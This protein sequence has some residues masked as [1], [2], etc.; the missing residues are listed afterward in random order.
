MRL[1]VKNIL[2]KQPKSKKT[3][4]Y[5][6]GDSWVLGFGPE[7]EVL[8]FSSPSVIVI[9]RLLVATITRIHHLHREDVKNLFTE[10]VRKGGR[11][12]PPKSTLLLGLQILVLRIRE[13]PG[14]CL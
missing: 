14:I 10:S 3:S 2:N 13:V 4:N 9:A 1:K 6:A 8:T 5:F 7:E 11:G 12:V